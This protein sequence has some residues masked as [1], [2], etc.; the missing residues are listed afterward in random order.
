MKIGEY[1]VLFR[2]DANYDMSAW[3][4]LTL[5]FTKPDESFLIKTNP[6]VS[7]GATTVPTSLGTFLANQYVQYTFVAGDIDQAGDWEVFLTYESGPSVK[8]ISTPFL[9]KVD[10]PAC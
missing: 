9:F 1:G 5:T 4:A 8:L 3:T 7:L 10:N 6:A 2:F